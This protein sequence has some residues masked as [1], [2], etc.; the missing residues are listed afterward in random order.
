[1][2]RDAVPRAVSVLEQ[3][4]A[5]AQ[6]PREVRVPERAV[7]GLRYA[8]VRGQRAEMEFYNRLLAPAL[9]NLTGSVWLTGS[10]Y[11]I[12]RSDLEDVGAWTSLAPT[13]DLDLSA[14]LLASGRRIA[15]LPGAPLAEE[16]LVNFRSVLRQKER[17]VRGSMLAM[18]TALRNPRRTW[19]LLLFF[20]MPAWGY[21]LTPWLGIM[22]LALMN[23]AL[24]K[25]TLL[26]SV[27]WMGPALAYYIMS[28]RRAGTRLRPLPAIIGVYLM[29]GV[30][31]LVKLFLARY[32][33]KGSRA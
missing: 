12:W 15:L 16:A 22:G 17:W 28:L 27:A 3:G 18:F 30:A 7:K 8:Y 6:L 5:A 26:W 23:P 29:A 9:M 1:M 25:W 21:L 10:G 14:K 11:F 20:S 32:D 13:E 33:W 19:P 31:A 4:Y 2:P 24:L